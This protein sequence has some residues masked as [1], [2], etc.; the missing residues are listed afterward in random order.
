M[1]IR[2]FTFNPYQE[3]TILIWDDSLT[4]VI[5]DPGCIDMHEMEQLTG[6]IAGRGIKPAAILLTH[7]HF[8]HIYGVKGCTGAYG[9]PVFMSPEDKATLDNA[10]ALAARSCMPAPDTSWET[11]DI[12]DGQVLTFGDMSFKVMTTPGHSPGSACFF[13]EESGDL[14]CGDTLFAGTIGRTDLPGGDYDSE[15]V[16]VMD[17]V[18]GLDSDVEIHP[19]HGPSSNI[20]HE[21]TH[22]PFLQPFNEKD[23]DSGDVEGIEISGF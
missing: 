15:I 1:N 6:F 5:I 20:G 4:G 13:C 21:R 23:E 18:M 14:F 12:S 10:P 11:I 7:A 8:D 22:N 2:H 9:I 17:K 16:S 19:G 3:N